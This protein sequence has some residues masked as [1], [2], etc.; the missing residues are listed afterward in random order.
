MTNAFFIQR[1][2]IDVLL[3]NQASAIE[4]GAYLV[5]SKYTDKDGYYSGV[6]YKTIKERLGIGQKKADAAIKRLKSMVYEGQKLLFSLAGWIYEETGTLDTERYS[7]GW[8]RGWF[9][10]EYNHQVWLSNDL[11]G[12]H[13]EERAPIQFFTKSGRDNH[14]R[15]FLMMLKYC[16][17][18]YSGIN[19]RFLSMATRIEETCVINDVRFYRSDLTNYH[20]SNAVF[21]KYGFLLSSK[22]ICNLLDDMR[23]N[24]F[25]SI[26]ISAIGEYDAPNI[27]AEKNRARPTK[28]GPRTENQNSAYNKYLEKTKA[29]NAIKEKLEGS[30]DSYKLAITFHKNNKSKKSNKPFSIKLIKWL[31]TTPQRD[32]RPKVF[33]PLK[34]YAEFWG[35]QTKFVYRLDYKSIL[36]KS[37]KLND[38]L[39]KRI[40]SVV[41]RGGLEPASRKGKFYNTYWWFDPGV[42]A[43]ALVGV[44]IPR[45]TLGSKL[46]E[47]SKTKEV[48][49]DMTKDSLVTKQ[50]EIDWEGEAF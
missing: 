2:A 47:Y 37:M 20:I 15:L 49:K 41:K 25:V 23:K 26:S 22:E 50:V 17:R 38:C 19:Y 35:P 29:Y 36:K 7:V 11:I 28:N 16:N 8:V 27:D 42:N 12:S 46:T 13:G 48:L 21:E 18:Q 32:F 6:G 3:L 33:E 5:I 43:I 31:K 40:E 39:A 45:F 14:A 4:I 34:D 24:G 1:A 9:E 30:R 10:S 44:L